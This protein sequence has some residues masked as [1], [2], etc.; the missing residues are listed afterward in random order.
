MWVVS[1][2]PRPLYPRGKSLRYPSNG[3][4]APEPVLMT[5]KRG[6]SCPYR[7]S[8][9]DS[10]AVQ[11]VASR[12]TDW[13]LRVGRSIRILQYK[14][15]NVINKICCEEWNPCVVYAVPSIVKQELFL[16]CL[17]TVTERRGQ[18]CYVMRT[19]PNLLRYICVVWIEV[20]TAVTMKNASSW[21]WK[22]TSLLLTLVSRSRIF[23]SW[24]WRRFIHPKR[25]F[26]QDL[27]GATS[28]NTAFYICVLHWANYKTVPISCSSLAISTEGFPDFPHP[29]H[30]NVG[31]V[32]QI[33]QRPLRVR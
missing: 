33:A 1:F 15:T 24:R 20:F 14:V 31:I 5:C 16:C 9:S 17:E 18:N 32:H 23:L 30:K 25:R 7:D 22:A 4:W 28:Q 6:N 8:N 3:S 21:M 27:H 26:T 12:Y 11:H 13:A 10:S 2:T 29:L 19:F